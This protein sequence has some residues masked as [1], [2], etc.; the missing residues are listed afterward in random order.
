MKNISVARIDDRLIHGQVVTSWIK[1]YPV[2]KILIIDEALVK[3]KLMMRIYKASAPSDVEVDVMD[4]ETATD[5]L[6]NDSKRENLLLL[7]KSPIVY[8][9]LIDNGVK[10]ETI[11]L[12]GMGLG[13]DRK[14]INKNIAMSDKEILSFKKILDKG[15]KVSYK[16]VPDSK[17]ID[18]NTWFERS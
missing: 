10:I 11:I 2:D 15:I 17:D 12:G 1:V 9:K 5:Y 13:D 7:T 8:E 3:N 16:M 18:V 4:V 6:M 14:R